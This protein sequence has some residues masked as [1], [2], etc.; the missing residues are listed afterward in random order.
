MLDFFIVTYLGHQ[1]ARKVAFF[2]GVAASLMI[3]Y[4]ASYLMYY[5]QR[6]SRPV[7]SLHRASLDLKAAKPNLKNIEI[8]G[9][10]HAH[11]KSDF[12]PISQLNLRLIS[13]MLNKRSQTESLVSIQGADSSTH[14][15]KVGDEILPGITLHKVLN[16]A[17][18]VDNNHQQEMIKLPQYENVSGVAPV[19]I[20][21][22]N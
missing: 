18:I 19:E 10:Y 12:V 13:I 15:Y 9:H 16:D 8:Y 14:V 17:V 20:L 11:Q 6:I 7:S 21:N 22:V 3:F 5:Y 4:N 2:V 1:W